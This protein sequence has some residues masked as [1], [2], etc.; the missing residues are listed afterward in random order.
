MLGAISA[1]RGAD[2]VPASQLPPPQTVPT[3]GSGKETPE[4]IQYR[5]RQLARIRRIH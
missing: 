4:Q 2:T 1:C 5:R 3:L